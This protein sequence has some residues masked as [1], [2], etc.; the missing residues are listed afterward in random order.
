MW[1]ADA[2]A[3]DAAA[4]QLV[5][6]ADDL[7]A[8]AALLTSNLG[9]IKWIGDVAIRFT[10]AWSSGHQPRLRSV[11]AYLRDNAERLQHEAAEQRRVS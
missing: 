3:L 5:S 8:Q 10:D 4:S 2:D 7:D 9:A 6:A 11:S 1:G